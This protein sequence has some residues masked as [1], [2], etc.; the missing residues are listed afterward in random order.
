[1]RIIGVLGAAGIAPAAVLTPV[2]RRDDVVVG[3]VASR[4]GARHYAD[5]HGIPT[6][7]DAYEALL[8]DPSIDLVYN[9]LPP[10][11][12]AEWT[13]AALEAG[14]DVLC[15]KPFTMTAAEARR[16]VTKAEETG[17]RAV[18]AFHDFYHPLQETVRGVLAD[19][20]LG[21][22]RA[23]EAVFDGSNPYAPDTIRHEPSLGGGALMDLGCDPVHWVRS[24]F[25]EPTVVRAAAD[26]NPSGA[27]LTMRAELTVG[28]DAAPV[29]LHCSMVEGVA[30]RSAIVVQGELG[31]LQVENLVF[32]SAGHSVRLTLGDL[33]H[34]STVAG[35]QTYDHQLEAVL[36]AL[37]SGTPLPTEGGDPVG[38]MAVIDAIYAAAGFERSWA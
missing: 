29:S 33:P 10:S 7:Y 9:A 5:L 15:E 28:A 3:A 27:D 25:G 14:K 31:S 34:V 30:L 8:A 2:R 18:E 23:V 11:L 6:A 36:A 21:R 24:M 20:V 16:V 37:D 19:G 13:I 32:P 12:H 38:N 35:R 1:M 17:H 22:I 4:S 26:R